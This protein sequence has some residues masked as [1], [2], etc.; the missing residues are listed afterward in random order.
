MNPDLLE[1]LDLDVA[2]AKDEDRRPTRVAFATTPLGYRLIVNS[3]AATANATEGETSTELRL[4]LYDLLGRP[5][6]EALKP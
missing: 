6:I 1:D 3:L 5:D 4:A 2:N